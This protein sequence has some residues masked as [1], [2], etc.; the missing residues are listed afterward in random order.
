MVLEGHEAAVV[1][2]CPPEIEGSRADGFR[3]QD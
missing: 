2:P 3:F 1:A